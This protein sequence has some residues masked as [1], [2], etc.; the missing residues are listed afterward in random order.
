MSGTLVRP[1]Q[2][3]EPGLKSRQQLERERT[4]QEEMRREIPIYSE[5]MVEVMARFCAA[6][7]DAANKVG[8][9]DAIATVLQDA[10]VHG[11]SV[12]DQERL[13]EVVDADGDGKVT[14]LEAA[15]AQYFLTVTNQ[16]F[17]AP[18]KRGERITYHGDVSNMKVCCPCP[19]SPLVARAVR[20]PSDMTGC[21]RSASTRCLRSCSCA[22]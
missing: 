12:R 13:L 6:D 18:E 19:R 15:A 4:D 2:R 14:A 8:Y 17:E 5:T 1:R 9:T 22:R 7:P 3:G 16:G 20:R 10:D 11:M 21:G